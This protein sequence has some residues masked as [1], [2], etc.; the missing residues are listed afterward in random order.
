MFFFMFETIC[1]LWCLCYTP[2]MIALPS[3]CNIL[4]VGLSWGFIILSFLET[5]QIITYFENLAFL[6]LESHLAI[7][8]DVT[9]LNSQKFGHDKQ[10][11][12]EIGAK[13]EESSFENTGRMILA[14]GTAISVKVQTQTFMSGITHY[15]IAVLQDGFLFNKNWNPKTD[16]TSLKL[17]Y[18]T[19]LCT[20]G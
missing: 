3:L 2:L 16:V 17:I 9:F 6:H 12:K 7:I 15:C 13:R 11:L 10:Y 14:N 1:A 5:L 18:S 8:F 20:T 4:S 19:L